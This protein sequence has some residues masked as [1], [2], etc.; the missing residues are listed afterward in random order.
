[1]PTALIFW[2]ALSKYAVVMVFGRDC[3]IERASP[4]RLAEIAREKA[5]EDLGATINVETIERAQEIG[6]APASEVSVFARVDHLLGI[7]DT[8]FPRTFSSLAEYRAFP[9]WGSYRQI[10]SAIDAE[11]PSDIQVEVLAEFVKLGVPS[12]RY[13]VDPD[14]FQMVE[15]EIEWR[16]QK[17]F[18]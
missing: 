18:L 10:E 12:G 13:S 2:E 11:R 6:S 17:G 5:S 4:E 7:I 3:G 9:A 15:R 8:E 16:R 1:M 14:V